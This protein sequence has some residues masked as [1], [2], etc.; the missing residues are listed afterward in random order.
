M[1]RASRGAMPEKRRSTAVTTKKKTPAASQARIA[2]QTPAKKSV[3]VPTTAKAPALPAARKPAAKPR[4]RKPSAGS[5][6][7]A[8]AAPDACVLMVT[9]E[10]YPF[11]TTGGLAEVAGGLSH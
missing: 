3:P 9:S 2:K 10:A 5:Q 8:A 1:N 11:A 7:T 6:P 4:T